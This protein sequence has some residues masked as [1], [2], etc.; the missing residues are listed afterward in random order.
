MDPHAIFVIALT[1]LAFVLF[2]SEK[3]AIETVALTV[4]AT[5]LLVFSVLPY[6]APDG[7]E[8][9][10][11]NLLLGFGHQALV[12]IC[13]LMILGRGLL[14]TGALEPVAR[15]LARAF[16]SSPKLAMLMLLCACGLGSAFVNDTPIVVVAMPILIGVAVRLKQPPSRTLL[17][18]N[19]AVLIGG[20]G[21]TIGT[22]TNLLVVTIAADL[23]AREFGMFDFAHIT[24]IAAVFGILYLWLVL[25]KLL[26]DREGALLD[27]KPQ[28]F[29]SELYVSEGSK[30]IG[31]TLNEL[32]KLIGYTLDATSVSRGHHLRTRQLGHLVLKADDTVRVRDTR[33]NLKRLE[34]ELGLS[35]H[36]VNVEDEER[37]T[38]NEQVAEILITEESWLAGRTV[39]ELRLAENHGLIVIGLRRPG[40]SNA[41]RRMI[42]TRLAAGDM[43]LVQGPEA[44]LD[45]FRSRAAVLMLDGRLDLPRSDKAW[46]AMVIMGI[47]VGS[48]ALKI[49][50]I[51]ISAL[52]GVVAM[53][54]SGCLNWREVGRALSS[55]VIL[56][57]V[58]S[59]ALGS[60]LTETG[61]AEGLA[62][63]FLNLTLGA[64]PTVVLAA[65]MLLV[66]AITNFVS[67]T[68]AAAV[69]TPIAVMVANQLGVSPEPFVLAVLFGANLCYATPM[70]YQTNLLVMSAAGYRFSDFVRGGLPLLV[71]MWTVISFLLPIFFPMTPR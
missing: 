42:D 65:L 18:M 44:A 63:G 17:P 45:G 25:P 6:T 10:P 53:I 60:A 23:G 8:F 39:R 61:G 32:N 64:G 66:A 71:L 28:V 1:F 33:A 26:P 43:L 31:K 51:A 35:L 4:L 67:N 52:L 46:L 2:A 55:K 30:A 50:P 62:R 11:V 57:V 49:L 36:L 9:N 47:V 27:S 41:T 58:S 16:N 48:A 68:A 3:V 38:P 14:V 15:L 7:A 12:A 13:A 21:T 69:G 59:L 37:E 5:L 22:S 56:L 24:A 70:A 54:V 29:E 40:D 34:S 20:M 19:Y